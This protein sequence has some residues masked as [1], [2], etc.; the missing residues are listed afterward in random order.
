MEPASP[1]L[2]DLWACLQ[3]MVPAAL[4]TC[5][6]DGTP[7]I[8]F[9]SQVYYVDPAHVAI[10]H[11]FFNKTHR[12]VR[13]NPL[14][15]AMMLDPR[16]LQGYRLGLRF[17]HSESSGS[18]FESMSLQLQAI[19]SHA[20]MADVFR[21]RAADVYRVLRIERI[22]GFT[23]L[24][25]P[26]PSELPSR[27]FVPE[28]VERLRLCAE[29]LN[30]AESLN[31][32]LET[33]LQLL[34]DVLQFRYVLILL[35]DERNGKLFTI[36]SRG[37]PENGVGSEVGFGE[38]LIGMVAR[39]RRALRLSA[40]DHSLRYARAAREQAQ[41]VA[42]A[43]AVCRE[44]PFPG[45]PGAAAQIAVPLVT[46]GRLV[47]VVAVESTDP[48]AFMPREDTMLTIV[49]AQLAT[50]IE[51]LGREADESAASSPARAESRPPVARRTRRFCF[52][53]QDDCVFVDGDY[54]IRNVPGRILWRLL[55]EHREKGRVEFTNRELRMDA[56]IGL[57]EYKDNLESRLILLRKRMEQ[58]C[59]DVRL[60]ARG[61]GRFALEADAAIELSEK[62]G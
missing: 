57:P 28:D 40:I 8:T 56:W 39:S 7:N 34:D 4:S 53:R 17:D 45:L 23:R 44:I 13:E 35:A 5:A 47:G 26:P 37:Y 43:E 24:S 25:T 22:D 10:S 27:L 6:A 36:A 48:L 31:D 33:A 42:G 15:C 59:P 2:E 60:V 29:R 1:R 52:Y 9:I 32:L 11:Q 50:G 49:A 54:L 18:L 61:R 51:Q 38:G 19:A 3:G 14:A 62:P 21:L 30:R 20:G 12:N 55:S 41:A 16:T 46:R 58:K